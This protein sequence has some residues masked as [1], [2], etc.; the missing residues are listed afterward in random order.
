MAKFQPRQIQ[1]GDLLLGN[2]SGAFLLLPQK[3]MRNPKHKE[4]EIENPSKYHGFFLGTQKLL[5]GW[6]AACDGEQLGPEVQTGFST[7]LVSAEKSYSLKN[8]KKII[9]E[10]FVPDNVHAVAVS[11]SGP[12]SSLESSP[13]WTSAEGMTIRGATIQRP[14]PRASASRPARG[15]GR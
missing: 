8:G 7:D 6:F 15:I 10:I 1:G 9:E 13:S 4:K 5:E 12:F 14:I 2:G 11:Y 3:Q